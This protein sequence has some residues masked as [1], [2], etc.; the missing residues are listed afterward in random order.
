M[1]IGA[2]KGNRLIVVV[3]KFDLVSQSA[4]DSDTCEEMTEE[5]VKKQVCQFV[6]KACGVELSN[7][8]VLVES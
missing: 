4:K 6:H 1:F 5:K 8:D 3:T 7:D 2:F